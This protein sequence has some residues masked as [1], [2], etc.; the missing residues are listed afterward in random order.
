MIP[1]KFEENRVWRAYL[2]G[3]GID[4]LHKKNGGTDSR[5]PEDWIA[6]CVEAY[7]PQYGC[8]GQGLSRVESGRP[9]PEIL[10]ESP[11]YWLGPSHLKHFGAVPGFLMKV[12]DSA[13]RLPIQAHPTIS[14]AEK[15]YHAKSGKTECWIILSTRE[16]NGEKPYL[17][18]G[19]NEKLNA[20][21]FLDEA[22]LGKFERGSGML[23]KW[24]VKAGN[25]FIVPGGV[26]HAIGPGVTL[27]EVM[28]PSDRVV[29][30]ELFCGKQPLSE[31]DRFGGISPE[32]ALRIFKMTS[33][34]EDDAK[35]RYCPAAEIIDR[36]AGFELSRIVPLHSVKLFEVQKLA[37]TGKYHYINRE[38]C[39]RA[40]VVTEGSFKIDDTL[41]VSAGE[42][43][44]L[45]YG[46]K[47]CELT[48]EGSILFA[49]PEYEFRKP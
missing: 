42:S 33:E 16:V 37:G 30:P 28:E 20:D 39:C 44:F 45:P 40:G 41:N 19:F 6:S 47:T 2:G 49:L 18:L 22:R 3:S 10:R 34:T 38:D 26:P 35:R 23:R 7:N 12:L 36:T 1:I 4:R 8:P 15:Y 13:E 5:F 24:D 21:I 27:I 9:F 31:G 25:V 14:D 48:G 32:Y 46:L 17:L 11:E 43:F 29:Q